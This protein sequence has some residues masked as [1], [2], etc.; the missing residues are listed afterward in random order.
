MI[1]NKDTSSLEARVYAELEE[2]ILSGDLKKGEALTELG[3]SEKLG[4][5]RTPVRG[6]LHRL[7]EEGLIEVSPNRGAVVVGVTIDD[8]IDIYRIRMRLEGLAAAMAAVKMT[9]EGKK[10]LSESV[11]L[12]EFYLQKQDPE[13]LKELDTTFHGE[14]YRA[15][16]SRNLCR[17]LSAACRQKQI[18]C[19]MIHNVDDA[20]PQAASFNSMLIGRM[21]VEEFRCRKGE[22]AP[23]VASTRASMEKKGLRPYW[24]VWQACECLRMV[25]SINL[26]VFAYSNPL[27]CGDEYMQAVIR[28]PDE[29]RDSCQCRDSLRFIIYKQSRNEEAAALYDLRDY[30]NILRP[31]DHERRECSRE[32]RPFIK[33]KNYS[34]R[35]KGLQTERIYLIIHLHLWFL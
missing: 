6:A 32:E 35:R 2:A 23:C 31:S 21:G 33:R 16:G 24:C 10:A 9:S 11:E 15:C 22:I 1:I 13:H 29:L 7:A 18:P 8:L 12:S 14:I 34:F 28:K 5:S 3:I 26:L 4:V 30:G 19:A 20:D 25:D 17:I 27:D